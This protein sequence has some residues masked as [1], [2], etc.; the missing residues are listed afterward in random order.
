MKLR[1]TVLIICTIIVSLA[2]LEIG[3]RILSGTLV[4]SPKNSQVYDE[5]LGRKID[6]SLPDIDDNGF[7]NPV[8][9]ED[10][11]VVVLGD[12]HTYGVNVKSGESWPAQLARMSGLSVYNMGVGGYG[13]LQYYYLFDSAVKLKPE[14]I[15]LALFPAND[16]NDVCKLIDES[17]YWR[18]WAQSRGYE[19]EVCSGSSSLLGRLNRKLSGL[20]VYWMAASAIKRLNESMNFGDSV[21]VR[22]G[23]SKTI[24]KHAT[25]SSH[26]KK[27]DISRERIALGLAVTEDLLRE[28]K[29][30]AES[31][32]IE[33]SVVLIPSKERVFYDYLKTNGYKLTAEYEKLVANENRVV[34]ELEWFFEKNGIEYSDARPYVTREVY[35]SINAYSPTDDGHPLEEGYE[36]Y[37][38]A[39]YDGILTDDPGE[40]EALKASQ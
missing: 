29:R 9:P 1:K 18:A 28:M 32:G 17:E 27:M 7:R 20:H 22:S 30:K 3:L 35:E 13:T 25:I 14:R 15:I 34:R 8:V 37:A 16:L 5:R 39:V 36:A 10:T 24:M 33:F 26:E 6:P 31:G 38:R 4:Y 21:E 11:G 12:S 40:K 23:G 2:V 19:V